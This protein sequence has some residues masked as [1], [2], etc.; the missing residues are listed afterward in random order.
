MMTVTLCDRQESA[1]KKAWL[2]S[3]DSLHDSTRL[4]AELVELLDDR[5]TV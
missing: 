3:L 1:P 4:G 2:D 5:N